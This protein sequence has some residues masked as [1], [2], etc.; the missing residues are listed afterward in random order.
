MDRFVSPTLFAAQSF[1]EEHFGTALAYELRTAVELGFKEEWL[2]KAIAQNVDLVIA[3][4][5]EA[6]LTDERWW[7]WAREVTVGAAGT[8]DLLLVSESGRVAIVETKL[9]YNPEKRR[10]VIAQVLEY[11]VTLPDAA[12]ALPAL[13]VGPTVSMSRVRQR[14][15]QGDYLLIVAGD[16]LDSR[17]V[18]L[19]QAV[20]SQHIVNQWQLAMV[21]VSVFQ[22][23]HPSA[24]PQH[25]LVSHL[26]GLI[27]PEFRQVLRV[28]V[29]HGERTRVSVEQAE[30]RTPGSAREKWTRDRFVEALD[31]T[32][33]SNGYKRFGHAL[34]DMPAEFPG[35]EARWGT[36]KTGSLTLKR[37]GQGLVEFYLSGALG[38]RRERPPAALGEP[39]ASEYL[40]ALRQIFPDEMAAEI[41]PNSPTMVKPHIRDAALEALLAALRDALRVAK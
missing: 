13:P 36:G 37:N 17:A 32:P 39:A 25:L 41:D 5:V 24:A 16:E 8:I 14:I 1:D 12:E 10:T 30:P 34:A 27:V 21:E 3:P 20:L 11:A 19:G 40:A 28:E 22:A 4:C 23:V 9:S 31:E 15:E 18:R 38:F 26:R 33:L 7:F 29:A 6:E 2:Q 35:V